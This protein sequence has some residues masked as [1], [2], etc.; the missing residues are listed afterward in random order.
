MK[1]NYHCP[2]CGTLSELIIGTTQAFCTNESGCP[3]LT[4]DPSFPD[5]GMSNVQVIKWEEK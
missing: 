2:I 5:G 3:I 1:P 4:F